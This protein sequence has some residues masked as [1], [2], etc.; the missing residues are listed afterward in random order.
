[1]KKYRRFIIIIFCNAVL[2]FSAQRQLQQR[3]RFFC[4]SSIAIL[5]VVPYRLINNL[6]R[7]STYALIVDSMKSVKISA[8][9]VIFLVFVL[10]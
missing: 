4:V 5:L 6:I 2:L 10:F 9:I 1:M 7:G 3:A 8:P